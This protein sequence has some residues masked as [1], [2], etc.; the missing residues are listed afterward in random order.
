[1]LTLQEFSIQLAKQSIHDLWKTAIRPFL[2]L[3]L[4]VFGPLLLTQPSFAQESPIEDTASESYYLSN[5]LLPIFEDALFN[6]SDIGIHIMNVRT[7]E[8]VFSYRGDETFIPASV[9]KALTSAVALQVLGPDFRFETNFYVDGEITAD[10]SLNGNLY[11]IGGGDPSMTT[12][13]LWTAVH[14]LKVLGIHSIKGNVYFDDSLYMGSHLLPGW[15]KEVDIA[16][17]P[18]YFPALSALSINRNCIAIKVRPSKGMAKDAEV[19]LEYPASFIEID[20]QVRTGGQKARPRMEITRTTE[21]DDTLLY[22]INGVIPISEEKP[23]TYYRSIPDPTLLFM[24]HFEDLLKANEIKVKGKFKKVA[25]PHD[26]WAFYTHYS[27]PLRELVADMNKHS[28][29]LIAEH[30]LIQLGVQANDGPARTEDGVKVVN[31]YLADLGLTSSEVQLVNG[32]GLSRKLKIQPSLMTAVLVEMF[33]Q[34]RF[35]PEYLGSLAVAG[36]EGTMRRRL[37]DPKYFGRVRGKTG[38]INGVYCLTS[39]VWAADGEVYALAFFANNLRRSPA[40]VRS[41][42]DFMISLLL[43]G[44]SDLSD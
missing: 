14:H 26:A 18:A 6:E 35:A 32:S 2:Q 34:D 16:N 43:D 21:E 25:P 27:P 8:E 17:G 31:A 7:K 29:N 22:T 9:M 40:Y 10:H 41:L 38:S 24:E 15:D 37:R 12:A 4:L 30:L 20:N 39:Y 3:L 42:Q 19:F 11:V 36:A 28:V 33:E 1:M 13:K 23:W 5:L 44:E